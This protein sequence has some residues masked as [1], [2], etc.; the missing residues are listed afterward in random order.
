[1]NKVDWSH[2]AVFISRYTHH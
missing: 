1:M 2:I